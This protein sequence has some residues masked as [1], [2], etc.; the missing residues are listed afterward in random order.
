MKKNFGEMIS[1]MDCLITDD[2]ACLANNNSNPN[3]K[4]CAPYQVI[5]ML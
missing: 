2:K 4:E 3:Y 5:L 1:Y